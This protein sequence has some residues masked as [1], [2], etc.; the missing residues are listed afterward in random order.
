[1]SE[2]RMEV[3]DLDDSDSDDEEDIED[4]DSDDSEI[5]EEE[6]K[7]RDD[8]IVI[9]SE[10]ED[11]HQNESDKTSAS[12]SEDQDSSSDESE[13]HEIQENDFPEPGIILESLHVP[14]PE[15]IT[16]EPSTST[17]SKLPP[18]V[19]NIDDYD[20]FVDPDDEG[21]TSKQKENVLN[22]DCSSN[23]VCGVS[24]DVLPFRDD[25]S[26]HSFSEVEEEELIALSTSDDEIEV[27]TGG[28][29]ADGNVISEET[30][31]NS[32][33]QQ[34]PIENSYDSVS[35][36]IVGPKIFIQIEP[37]KVKANLFFSYNILLWRVIYIALF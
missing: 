1:M 7:N 21:Q 33:E 27:N 16:E 18:V 30:E 10:P 9:L 13:V 23:N 34:E 36:K 35:F 11:S 28:I 20:C 31:R 19:F 17:G 24:D 26:S 22:E 2:G 25:I 5:E 4:S 12:G 6:D 8:E 37:L 29:I 14:V 32:H 15:P 3:I